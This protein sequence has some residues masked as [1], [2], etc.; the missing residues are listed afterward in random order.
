MATAEE[1]ATAH[2]LQQQRTV[3]QAADR[4]QAVWRSLGFD[5]AGIDGQWLSVG[6]ALVQAVTDGQ[7]A[8]AA[9][10]DAYVA[11][12]VA[13]DGAAGDPAGQVRTGAFTGRAADGRSLMSLLYEPVIDAKWRATTGLPGL[14]AMTGG[15]A[16][17]LRAVTT[18]VADA[19]RTAT[20]VGIAGNRATRGYVRVL[21]PPSCARCAV[22][23][24]KEYAFNAG[25]DRHP[26]C[27]CVHLPMTR[28]RRGD[29]TMD[30]ARYFH[31]LSRAEQDR[32]F[33]IHGAQAIRDGA[34]INSVV[35]ARRG[36]YQAGVGL[37]RV[38]ATYDATTVRGAFFRSERERA[39]RLGL[40][41][42]SQDRRA[43]KLTTRRLLPEEIYQRAETRDQLISMLRRYGYL[44]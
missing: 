7:Q 40:I 23:A 39:I 11:A 42:R 25:F 28:Y 15:L 17:L 14:E 27:D 34:D 3:R 24:G 16:T 30:T 31:S 33:T 13:A 41:P 22:L 9:P 29:R 4:A 10:A 19:G 12:V 2:Y 36:M 18:E 44:T 20:G 26:H 37:N 21:S 5:P 1:L 6:P 35:N 32:V 8:A 38:R 43:F